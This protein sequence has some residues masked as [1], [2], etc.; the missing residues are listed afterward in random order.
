METQKLIVVESAEYREEKRELSFILLLMLNVYC[1]I[2]RHDSHTGL[3][4]EY[5]IDVGHDRRC[6]FC[7]NLRREKEKCM[8]FLFRTLNVRLHAMI[9][10]SRTAVRQTRHRAKCNEHCHFSNTKLNE[11]ERGR[12]WFRLKHKRVPS[13]R[14]HL[15]IAN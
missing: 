13:S 6:Q 12:H 15:P 5:A 4:T 11:R 14:S 2:F 3:I 10:D 9:E 7:R 8:L 1:F